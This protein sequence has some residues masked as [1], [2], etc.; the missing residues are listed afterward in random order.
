MANDM[1]SSMYPTAAVYASQALLLQ[2]T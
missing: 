1:H 2:T